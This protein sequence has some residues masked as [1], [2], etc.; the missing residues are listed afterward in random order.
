MAAGVESYHTDYHRGE[1][2]YYLSVVKPLSAKKSCWARVIAP[3]RGVVAVPSITASPIRSCMATPP[4]DLR[5]CQAIMIGQGHT[6][7]GHSYPKE[8]YPDESYP[9]EY[10]ATQ[11]QNQPLSVV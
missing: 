11:Q 10:H 4:V 6:D 7:H 1:T 2:T 3:Q 8:S 9:E 5:D